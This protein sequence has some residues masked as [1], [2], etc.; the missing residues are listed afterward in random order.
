MKKWRPPQSHSP[1]VEP[2]MNHA[3]PVPR[4]PKPTDRQRS[5]VRKRV[6]N[7]TTKPRARRPTDDGEHDYIQEQLDFAADYDGQYNDFEPHV[8]TG[9]ENEFDDDDGEPVG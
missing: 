6:L 3:V 5:V 8:H 1:R 9:G 4:E 7:R 2:K